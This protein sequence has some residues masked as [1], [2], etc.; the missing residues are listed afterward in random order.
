ML[1]FS[2]E[3]GKIIGQQGARIK[4]INQRKTIHCRTS[5][6]GEFYPGIQK[7]IMAIRGNAD[8]V[9]LTLGEILPDL[10]DVQ[11]YENIEGKMT[12]S[13][14]SILG[15][16][17]LYVQV[18][19]PYSLCSSIIGVQAANMRSLSQHFGVKFYAQFDS[20]ILP[21]AKTRYF[22]ITGQPPSVLKSI[23]KIT[24]QI[25]DHIEYKNFPTDTI[26]SHSDFVQTMDYVKEKYYENQ[27]LKDANYT[28][29]VSIDP[30]MQGRVIGKGGENVKYMIAI[31]GARIQ[32][33]QA[34][35]DSKYIAQMQKAK[36][37]IQGNFKQVM[38]AQILLSDTIKNVQELFQKD[39]QRQVGIAD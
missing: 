33:E 31:S 27:V 4:D 32:V 38:R 2:P 34:S 6:V 15:N 7:R 26:T 22:E 9:F 29:E 18:F 20:A 25:V 5:N 11:N 39:Q 16:K 36:V 23:I 37:V 13:R 28:V 19:F 1:L 3:I 14:G 24:S 35:S 17:K 8:Q 21:L 10:Y 30:E 12:D